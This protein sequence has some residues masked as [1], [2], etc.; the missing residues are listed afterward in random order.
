MLWAVLA[1]FLDQL[2]QSGQVKLGTARPLMAAETAAIDRLRQ[3]EEA[4]RADFP[5]DA[6]SFSL[7]AG[8]WAAGILYR[9]CQFFAARDLPEQAVRADLSQPC[10]KPE[11]QLE[12]IYSVD[13]T[14]RY[15]PAL[16]R[17]A[18]A[19]AAADPLI[20]ELR[21]LADNWPLSGTGVPAGSDRSTRVDHF[22][23][24]PGLVQVYVDRIL[25]AREH[26]LLSTQQL[27]DV[28]AATTGIHFS[29]ETNTQ[30][31]LD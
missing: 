27:I 16:Y 2:F 7:D 14:F 8:Y 6:P 26:A 3:E 25:A 4:Y 22:M 23:S 30:G 19:R 29:E 15:L 31:S 10:P 12:V 9:A 28:A 20:E 5:G 1:P 21:A 13:I 17:L 18:A 11:N 24:H